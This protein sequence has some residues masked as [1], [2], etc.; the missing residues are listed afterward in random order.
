MSPTK[1]AKLIKTKLETI[2]REDLPSGLLAYSLC[3]K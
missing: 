1:D 2:Q 3:K